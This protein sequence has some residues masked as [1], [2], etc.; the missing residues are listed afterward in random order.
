M[1]KL[2]K[3]LVVACIGLCVSCD[4]FSGKKRT[5]SNDNSSDEKDDV[6]YYEDDRAAL[7]D[8]DVYSKVSRKPNEYEIQRDLVG[9]QLSE[10]MY[11]CYQP[12]DWTF[13]IT[14]GSISEFYIEEIIEDTPTSYEIIVSMLLSGPG[15]GYNTRAQ[16][17]YE[18]DE[19]GWVM[20]KLMSLG[21]VVV[22]DYR[23][24]DCIRYSIVDDGWGGVNCLELKNECDVNLAVGG[25]F[26]TNFGDWHLFTAVIEPYST[27]RV[28]G[29]MSGG[30]VTDY[31]VDFVVRPNY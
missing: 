15:H 21:M 20:I 1:S 17:R 3:L 27:R 16:I 5:S 9:R 30:S 31:E 7:P 28:G 26:L 12:A 25:H 29:T 4:D 2:V 10:G 24:V 6:E 13:T 23:Y 14:D 19:R 8:E 11:E 18:C 22:S